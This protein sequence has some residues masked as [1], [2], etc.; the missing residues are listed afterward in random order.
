MNNGFQDPGHQAKKNR[1]WVTRNERGK[2][3]D[4]PS[5]SR[6]RVSDLWCRD[7]SRGQPSR[8]PELSR[9]RPGRWR[10]MKFTRQSSRREN[11][12]ET[13]HEMCRGSASIIG[14]VGYWAIHTLRKPWGLGKSHSRRG[15]VIVLRTPPGPD[16]KRIIRSIL[17]Q[18]RQGS[19]D[20][21][22]TS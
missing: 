6:E 5:T 17:P 21:A 15:E 19:L 20:G 7:G 3:L 11:W 22:S 8:H 18:F 14:W 1:I 4:G 16:W 10:Q 9:W 13:K 12:V 2:L